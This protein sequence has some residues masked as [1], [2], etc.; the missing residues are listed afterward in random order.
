MLCGTFFL[1]EI[2]DMFCHP[3]QFPRQLLAL[4]LRWLPLLITGGLFLALTGTPLLALLLTGALLMVAV[5][6]SNLKNRLLNEPLVFT[7]FAVVPAFFRH[8]RFYLQAIPPLLRIVLGPI[9]AGLILLIIWHSSKALF[10]RFLGLGLSIVSAVFLGLWLH[11]MSQRLAPQPNLWADTQRMGLLP[12]M[13]LYVWRWQHQHPLPPVPPLDLFPSETGSDN[14]PE[15]VI[16]IQCESFADPAQLNEAWT[17]LPALKNA[18]AQALQWG[19]LAVS[20]LG[21]YTMRSE[22]GVL[23]GVDE[24]MLGFRQYDPFLT[25][26]QDAS[27]ALPARL[28]PLYPRRIFLH[29][30]NLHFYSRHEIM[31]A[32][33]FNMLISEGAFSPQDRH[34]L[35]TSDAALGNYL[36]KEI[37]KEKPFFCYVVTMENH[38]PW[39]KGRAGCGTGIEAWQHHAE[40]GAQMLERVAD[41]LART[42]REALLVFFG[43]HRPALESLPAHAPRQER[44]TPYVMLRFGKGHKG[45]KAI[46]TAPITLTP[47]ELHKAILREIK[48]ES[49]RRNF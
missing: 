21:A 20:G 26:L 11:F 30:Y 22:Y 29:P 33:G 49:G 16:V 13:L 41:E 17:T 7:D 48:M 31:P 43:D 38:G 23:F 40:N 8:P 12:T 37:Q 1:A 25:A 46:P 6:G 15:I 3:R 36:I 14:I 27:H 44:H 19:N 32:V 28:A 2:G 24:D 42:G 47:A 5:I 18:Q 34:G 4:P 35:Y 45:H 10:P 39:A 9:I